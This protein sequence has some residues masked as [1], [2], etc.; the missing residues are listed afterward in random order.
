MSWRTLAMDERFQRGHWSCSYQVTPVEQPP[1]MAEFL[2]IIR[3]VEGNETG[4]PAWLILDNR[5][6]MKP[7]I[8]DGIIECW[9]KDTSLADFWRA[10]PRGHM[11][12]TRLMQEDRESSER[13]GPGRLFSL[14]LPVWRTGECL[15]HASRLAS[16]LGAESVDLMMTW[17]GLEG[18]ELSPVG[19]PDRWIMPGHICRQHEVQTSI[20]T[21]AAGISDTLPELVRQ[22]VAPLY[23]HFDFFEPPDEIYATETERMRHRVR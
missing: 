1:G 7:Y 9:L 15:L 21:E 11:S 13:I 23:A 8:K 20:T 2:Q 12:L 5:P 4:W 14:T 3:E 16:R 6:E 18:R 22:L 19:S 10:D 17:S